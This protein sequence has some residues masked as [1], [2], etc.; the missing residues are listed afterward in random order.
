MPAISETIVSISLGD[1][2]HGPKCSLI[3]FSRACAAFLHLRASLLVRDHT[4]GILRNRRCQHNGSTPIAITGTPML[5]ASAPACR[6]CQRPSQAESRIR[7]LYGCADTPS[8]PGS[9]A[10][11]GDLPPRFHTFHQPAQHFQCL[12]AS[13][14][15]NAWGY[16]RYRPQGRL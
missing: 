16:C 10:V 13:R 11:Y 7:Q 2:N 3:T 5:S 12:H 6:R 9:Q 14:S 4:D 15:Q 1:Y 8:T